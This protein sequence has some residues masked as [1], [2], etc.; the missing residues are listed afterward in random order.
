VEV[1]FQLA[2]LDL[3][4]IC[5]FL[6]ASPCPKYSDV[7]AELEGFVVRDAT[8]KGRIAKVRVDDMQKLDPA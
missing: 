8:S 1:Y 3:A 2:K 5:V 6:S 4:A 7:N